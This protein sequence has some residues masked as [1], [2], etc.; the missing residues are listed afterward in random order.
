GNRGAKCTNYALEGRTYCGQHDPAKPY[1]VAYA[2][3]RKHERIGRMVCENAAVLSLL[4]EPFRFAGYCGPS[5]DQWEQGQK[6]LQ[7]ILVE[8][9]KP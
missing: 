4:Q 2:L 3:R 6:A 7:A 1:S 9:E 5:P 8:V